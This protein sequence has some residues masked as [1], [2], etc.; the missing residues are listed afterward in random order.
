MV[1]CLRVL[2]VLRKSTVMLQ[3]RAERL[4]CCLVACSALLAVAGLGGC[5]DPSAGMLS[6][7]SRALPP[8]EQMTGSL[9]AV[10]RSARFDPDAVIAHA[11][12]E[13]EMRRP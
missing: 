2:F 5:T 7:L 11:V 9:G 8:P 12:A 1:Y 6:G 3:S 4:W 10:R 13:H